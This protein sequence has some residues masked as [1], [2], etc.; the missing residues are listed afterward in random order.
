MNALCDAVCPRCSAKIAW[1][2][3]LVDRPPCWQ[4]RHEIPREQLQAEQAKLDTM[5]SPESIAAARV[6]AGKKIRAMRL[7]RG[8]W[9]THVARACGLAPAG[10]A[11][12]EGGEVDFTP[13][14]MRKFEQLMASSPVRKGASA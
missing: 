14:Q 10:Y 4:C 5:L 12:V 9:P 1:K 3:S 2:G 8:L 11:K 7:V 13:Q 6:E